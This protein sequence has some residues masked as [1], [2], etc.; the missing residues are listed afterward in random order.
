IVGLVDDFIRLRGRHK[1]LGQVVSVLIVMSFGLVV[2]QIS[3]F[4]WQVELGLLAYPF[5]MLW[6]LGAINSL[7]LIDGMDGLLSSVGLI[8]TIAIAA[9]AI[10]AGQSAQAAVAVAMAGALA[11]FL[12]YNFPPAS[13][14]L[15][16][17]GSML[18]GL[19]VGTL[20]IQSSLKT[21][22]T[23]AMCAPLA[24][25]SVPFFDTLMAIVRRKLTGRSI[26]TTDRGHLHHCLL[27]RGLSSTRVLLLVSA[28]SLLTAVSA[29]AS[30]AFHNEFLCV[31]TVAA[32]ASIL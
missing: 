18:I 1:L 8:L 10:L 15:G 21:T 17:S 22:A 25:L 11:A 29:L 28:F 2:H 26:Y 32:V 14:F 30:L 12:R 19:V 24:I 23:V 20:A 16:D 6:L 7:N 13:I 4:G 3:L 27:R 31:F 9:I 5:T